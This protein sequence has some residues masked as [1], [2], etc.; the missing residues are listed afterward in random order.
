MDRPTV[1]MSQVTETWLWT[2]MKTY[3]VYRSQP[4]RSTLL[5]RSALTADLD[6]MSRIELSSLM[7]SW[8]RG[9]VAQRAFTGPNLK[10][11][12]R[13]TKTHTIWP[14]S[15]TRSVYGWTF[16]INFRTGETQHKMRIKNF[17]RTC[18]W[19]LA[20][21][22]LIESRSSIYH[23][24]LITI[25][26]ISSNKNSSPRCMSSREGLAEQRS[27]RCKK[28]SNHKGSYQGTKMCPKVWSSIQIQATT[29]AAFSEKA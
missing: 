25:M 8:R 13:S 18:M 17:A 14:L 15:K 5:T 29:S 20:N 24:S 4:T 7:P 2:L 3:A 9:P 1:W 19:R 12:H 23:S 27:L 10:T 26:D 21:W 22:S 28:R 11:T 6:K 16:K